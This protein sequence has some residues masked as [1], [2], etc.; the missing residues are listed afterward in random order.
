LRDKTIVLAEGRP[1]YQHQLPHQR[2]QIV[3]QKAPSHAQE[4][5]CTLLPLA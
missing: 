4:R 1:F 3:P 2:D 5:D